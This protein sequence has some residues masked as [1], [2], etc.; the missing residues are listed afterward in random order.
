MRE[1]YPKGYFAAV[2]EDVSIVMKT[3]MKQ[4]G[5]SLPILRTVWLRKRRDIVLG[6]SARRFVANAYSA[7][8]CVSYG[9]TA[10]YCAY[11]QVTIRNHS[12]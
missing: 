10:P 2:L 3:T 11:R 9:R 4:S 7:F 12:S 1:N 5:S 8:F 6:L